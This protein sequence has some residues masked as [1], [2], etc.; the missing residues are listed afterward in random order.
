MTKKDFNYIGPVEGNVMLID[1]GDIKIHAH[2]FY[3]ESEHVTLETTKNGEVVQI[4]R[5]GS[6][7]CLTVIG[8]YFNA[9][10]QS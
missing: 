8:K 9:W 6:W 3:R 1:F 7:G 10:K 2:R 5:G 4:C